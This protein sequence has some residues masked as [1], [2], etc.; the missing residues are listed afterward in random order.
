MERAKTSMR[1]ERRRGKGAALCT[2]KDTLV[3]SYFINSLD[4]YVEDFLVD[5]ITPN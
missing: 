1:E 3:T 2:W 4:G 5:A